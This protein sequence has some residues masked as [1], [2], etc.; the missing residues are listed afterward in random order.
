MTIPVFTAVTG[1]PW[2][3]KL[4]A[5]LERSDHGITVARRCVDLADL[6]SAAASGAARAVLLSADLRRLDREAVARLAKSG[7]AVVGLVSP[8]DE[9][10]TARLRQLGIGVVASADADT[11][12]IV[13]AVRQGVA[14]L[15][16]AADLTLA[17]PRPGPARPGD[18]TPAG[19]S[20]GVGEVPPDA[21]PV[22][23]ARLVAVWGA[24][25][26]PGRTTVAVG[27]ADEAARLGVSTMLID[28]DSYGGVVAQVLGLLDDV[29]GLA[30]AARQ[31]SMGTLTD[32]SLAGYALRLGPNLS[33]LT[34]IARPDR[35]PELHADALRTVFEIARTGVGLIVVDCGFSIE[36]DEEI[37]YDTMAPRRNG[38]TLS[39]LEQA[40]LT[41]CVRAADPVGL[42]RMFRALS[43]LRA[44]LPALSPRIVLNKV[45]KGVI[46]G[47]PRRELAE[48]VHRYAGRDDPIYLPF[49]QRAVD[50]ALAIGKT[51]GE[52]APGSGLRIAL[53]D[54]ASDLVGVRRSRR[55]R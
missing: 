8:G 55:R 10:A 50:A 27:L 3:A 12:A 52:S 11:A 39:A 24:T 20:A 48:A 28:A 21:G 45:R 7:V 40:D 44:E 9:S 2:E 1:A 46:P 47:D 5:A 14:G 30:A 26:A 31:A 25:G 43:D 54:M 51:L 6:I 15:N 41:L 19:S 16:G 49:D 22:A 34:G 4:V 18:V 42:Q 37:V 13:E 35:W 33:V 17:D 53:A 23:R 29:P 32:Q 38:A 36:S